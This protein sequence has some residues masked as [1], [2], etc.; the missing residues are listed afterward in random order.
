MPFPPTEQTETRDILIVDDD[1]TVR[2]MLARILRH[3]GYQVVTAE[4]GSR[5]VDLCLRFEPRLIL[6][7]MMIPG[8]DGAQIIRELRSRFGDQSPRV[9]LV[10]ANEI[11]GEVLS[12]LGVVAY[13]QKPFTLE[14]IVALA[15]KYAAGD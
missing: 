7:D 5:V 14:S 9:A 6:L 11:P 13:L 12:E 15:K 8:A 2:N 4:D 3:H 10:T 1:R